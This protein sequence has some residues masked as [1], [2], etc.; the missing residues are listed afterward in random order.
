MPRKTQFTADEIVENAYALVKEDGMSGLSVKAV[1]QKIGCSTM[2]IYSYYDSLDKLKDAVV[3][4]GW[5]VLM[6]YETKK[7]TGDV[8][9]DHSM[10][11]IRF[12]MAEK[13]IFYCM[14]DGR[15]I[16]LQQKMSLVHWQYLFGCLQD[17]E[18]FKG[19]QREQI[20][21]I[22]YSR[23]LFTH[24]LA[25]SVTSNWGKILEIDGMVENLVAANSRAILEGY[26]NTYDYKNENIVFLDTEIKNMF[27]KMKLKLQKEKEIN[28]VEKAN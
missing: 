24:G 10:G 26:R 20:F 28:Q 23:A 13:N 11:Y 25:I 2:P 6:E 17:Y 22:R 3:E 18:G 27:E 15:N 7:Y 4:K 19:L 16:E 1:A 14:F 5:K 12:A 8:W 9:Y 21:L